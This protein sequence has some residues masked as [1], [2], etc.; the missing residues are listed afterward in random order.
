MVI[1]AIAFLSGALLYTL[2]SEYPVLLATLQ[3]GDA[4]AMMLLNFNGGAVADRFFY[5]YSHLQ[6]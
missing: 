3:T 2:F 6:T 4:R 1:V 5:G